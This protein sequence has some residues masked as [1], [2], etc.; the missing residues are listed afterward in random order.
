MQLAAGGALDGVG[1]GERMPKASEKSVCYEVL[2]DLNQHF[3]GV[4]QDLARIRSL[5]MMPRKELNELFVF[6]EEARAWANTGIVLGLQLREESD[7]AHFNSLRVRSE[8]KLRQR[9]EP[10]DL[11]QSDKAEIS[12]PRQKKQ[13]GTS[14]K[15]KR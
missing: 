7:W 4:L 8:R 10:Q 15:V 3:S 13:T 1:T 11:S 12:V 9:P 2:G 14:S 6:V 5:R